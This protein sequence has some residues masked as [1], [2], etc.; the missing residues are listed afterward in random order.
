MGHKFVKFLEHIPIVYILVK[1]WEWCDFAKNGQNARTCFDLLGGTGAAPGTGPGGAAL[2]PPETISLGAID[3]P[4]APDAPDAVGSA[5][6]D[7]GHAAV[8][9]FFNRL[10]EDVTMTLGVPPGLPVPGL[11]PGTYQQPQSIPDPNSPTGQFMPVVNGAA[12]T[13]W[14]ANVPPTIP[15]F[16]LPAA[17]AAD[18]SA[19]TSLP[20]C[21]PNTPAD[22]CTCYQKAFAVMNVNFLNLW[23]AQADLYPDPYSPQAYPFL[24]T[25]G[26][27]QFTMA[28]PTALNFSQAPDDVFDGLQTL[29]VPLQGMDFTYRASVMVLQDPLKRSPLRA[30][31]LRVVFYVFVDA[32]LFG[33]VGFNVD[34]TSPA[35]WAA[36]TGAQS[37]LPLFRSMR[38]SNSKSNSNSGVIITLQGPGGGGATASWLWTSPAGAQFPAQVQMCLPPGGVQAMTL[39]NANGTYVGTCVTNWQD[40]ENN[41]FLQQF[42]FPS[43]GL[44]TLAAIITPT[45]VGN[46]SSTDAA[47]ASNPLAPQPASTATSK[48]PCCGGPQSL[49]A[50]SACSEFPCMLTAQVTF[51]TNP[52]AARKR[53]PDGSSTSGSGS[54]SSSTGT[55]SGSCT[56]RALPQKQGAAAR[57]LFL[58]ALILVIVILVLVSVRLAHPQ[59]IF[60][61]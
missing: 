51:T 60:K 61:R 18:P 25:I 24:I 48:N 22:T 4:D 1:V 17:L 55:G 34:T 12:Q 3:A 28:P 36:M 16:P 8:L 23:S 52:A 19:I 53:F 9:Y 58:T 33:G 30:G 21:P 38:N 29:L 14:A 15:R 35:T 32:N 31:K 2:G 43:L 50:C 47:G 11:T 6:P 54:G 39:Q 56:V 49:A 59:G 10:S 7:P 37:S 44:G 13:M 41:T 27:Q 40:S 57:A 20:P 26:G 42:T 45:P 46:V 5:S